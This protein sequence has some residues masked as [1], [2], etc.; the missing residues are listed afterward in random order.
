MKNIKIFADSTCDLS[1]EE[2]K[3]LDIGIVPLKV[4]FDFETFKDG[5]DI[6]SEQLFQLVDKYNRLPLTSSPSPADFYNSFKPYV[7]KGQEIIYIGL[8]SKISSTIQNAK[9]AADFLPENSVYIVDS[10]NLCGATGALVKYTYE[11]LEKGLDVDEVIKKL[12]ILI[13]NYRLFFTVETLDYL[14]R[15][16]RCSSVEKIFGSMLNIKPIIEMSPEGLGVWKKTRGKRKAFDMMIKQ[17]NKDKDDIYKQEIQIASAPGNE[18]ELEKL[19]D[20]I[21]KKT[22]INKFNEYETGCV[23]SSHCGRGTIGFGY[24]LNR[25]D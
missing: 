18:L 8:S 6:S 3:K 7:S 22:G 15:G 14:H 9:L 1:S 11:F 23:I 5:V 13:P 12:K 10:L 2:A 24:F 17:L 16:G 19:K 25:V 21:T 4:S 20:I